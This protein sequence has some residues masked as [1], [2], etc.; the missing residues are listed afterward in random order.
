MVHL[1]AMR[2]MISFTRASS[3]ASPS[4]P[5]GGRIAFACVLVDAVFMRPVYA[6]TDTLRAVT[7][8]RKGA[9]FRNSQAHPILKFEVNHMQIKGNTILITGGGSGI[10]R[11][12]AE[13]FHKEGNH[14]IIAGRRKEVLDEV[15]AANE[16]MSAEVLDIDSADA[17]K[18]FA[19]DL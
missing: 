13:A 17:I 11:G 4:P 6:R 8:A 7:M 10:G 3:A 1:S 18:S 2:P 5:P 12:L 15:V 9:Y 16:G 19:A 14:V